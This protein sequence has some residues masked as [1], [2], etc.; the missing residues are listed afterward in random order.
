MH[1]SHKYVIITAARDEAVYIKET[2]KS[3]TSQTILPVKWV[4]VDDG[5]TDETGEIID[6]FSKRYGWIVPIHRQ[7]RG[8]RA[9]G[10]GVI[11]AF[12]E[13]YAEV[14]KEEWD[15]IVKLDADLLFENNYF[16]ECFKKFMQNSKLGIGGGEIYNRADSKIVKERN[17]H[18]HVRGATKIYRKKCWVS[19]GELIKAPGWDTLDEVKANMLG[20]ETYTFHD[21]HIIQLKQTGSADGSWKN[22]V[23]NGRGSYI[24]CYH[25]IYVIGKCIKKLF[26]DLNL[27]AVAGL[28]WGFFSS[29]LLK[30]D[31]ISDD[32]LKRYI[33]Q[34]QI[35]KIL[36]RKSIWN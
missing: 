31:Q 2:I 16:A 30:V 34:Q 7:N 1:A 26:L 29:Y 25:P 11:E 35:R 14:C 17:P 20:W 19:I 22:W 8:F 32:N 23:K 3:I 28:F 36:M 21:I 5:S 13:G 9:A 10:G 33:R 4:V 12:Y 18:F 27:V 15:F 24:S 6:D